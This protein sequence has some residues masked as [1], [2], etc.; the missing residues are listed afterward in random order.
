MIS[1]LQIAGNIEFFFVNSL[2]LPFNVG[3]IF[4]W[5]LLVAILVAGIYYAHKI[6]HAD[7]QLV[8][9][10]LLVIFI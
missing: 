3:F 5:M 4:A 7:L 6:N 8:A 1:A 2:G 9:V 10:C